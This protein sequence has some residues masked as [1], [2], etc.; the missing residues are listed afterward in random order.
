LRA[1][2]RMKKGQYPGGAGGRTRE[3]E[4]GVVADAEAITA[5]L[6]SSVFALERRWM[7]LP[8]DAWELETVT[9]R[10]H[11]TIREGIAARW[12][13]VEIHHVDLACDYGPASWPM[14]FVEEFLGRAISRLPPRLLP[15]AAES[16]FRWR[17]VDR[18]TTHSWLVD[19]EGV[20]AG[21]GAADVEVS[22]SGWQLL[23]WLCG[24]GDHGLKVVG[25]SGRLPEIS[26]Y[27]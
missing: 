13:E 22:G 14:E 16:G 24:R 21:A 25:G 17:L 11:R 7:M 3:I 1:H 15:A 2:P 12:R 19:T 10:S 27:G 18:N 9:L 5:G 23:A 20:G 6:R 26:V 4:E 8:E